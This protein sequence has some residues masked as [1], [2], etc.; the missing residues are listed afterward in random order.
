MNHSENE[1]ERRT[2]VHSNT[3]N[4]QLAVK[5][6]LEDSL[7]KEHDVNFGD[8]SALPTQYY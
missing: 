7:E 1:T 2:V 4:N 6:N 3:L 5:T 8:I